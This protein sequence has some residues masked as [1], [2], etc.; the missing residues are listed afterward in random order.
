MYRILALLGL[1][2]TAPPGYNRFTSGDGVVV[3]R[4]DQGPAIELYAEGVIAAPPEQVRAVLLDYPRHP[5]F[6]KHMAEIRVLGRGDR[7]LLVYQRLDLPVLSDRDMV[8]QVSWG[9]EGE[10]LWT[11]FQ[12]VTDRGPQPREGAV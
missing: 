10:V 6:M 4:R 1:L 11:R 12:A 7:S 3:Y 5:T 9:E 2:A 8:L